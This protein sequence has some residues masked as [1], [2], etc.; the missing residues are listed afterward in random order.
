[1]PTE[2][3]AAIEHHQDVMLEILAREEVQ[4]EEDRETARVSAHETKMKEANLAGV[5]QLMD[6]M[7]QGDPEWEKQSHIPT[8]LDGWGD[9]KDKVQVFTNEFVVS[10][11][12]N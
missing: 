4:A 12:A 10:A 2:V 7:T 6:N 3:A 1:M 11:G 5:Q 9:V 8:M